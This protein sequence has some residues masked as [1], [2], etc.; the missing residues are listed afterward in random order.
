MLLSEVFLKL[1]EDHFGVLVRGVSMGKL[2]TYQR[3]E[4]FKVHAHLGKLN[5]ETLRKAIP[6]L[7]IRLGEGDQDLAADLAQAILLSHLDLIL[8]VLEFLG[9]PNDNGFFAKDVDASAHLTPGWQ[10]RVYDQFHAAYPAPVLLLYINH[11]ASEL[12]A[13]AECFLEPG[14]KE[15]I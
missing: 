7:W 5:T 9:I 3:F 10:Q 15:D 12:D 11:L 14:E 4:S 1:G 2:R 13:S 6:R 8:A